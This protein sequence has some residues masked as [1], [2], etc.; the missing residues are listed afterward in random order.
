MPSSPCRACGVAQVNQRVSKTAHIK[1][2]N[3]EIDTLKAELF[4]TREKN[5]VYMPADLFQQRE[6]V[7]GLAASPSR[8]ACTGFLTALKLR[9]ALRSAPD[10]S[11]AAAR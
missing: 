11:R 3:Q 7:R 1:E 5:G 8:A 2:L 10:C 9:R 6:Q 4:A